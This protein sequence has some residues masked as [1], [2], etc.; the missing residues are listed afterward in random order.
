[1]Q[2]GPLDKSR[3]SLSGKIVVTTRAP[4]Q[5]QELSDA[6]EA[7]GAEVKLLPMVSF[8]PPAN[9]E[10]LDL[11]LQRL[12]EFDWL[13]FTSQNA[14]RFLFRRGCELKNRR[15][16]QPARPLV[17][18]VGAATAQAA[19]NLDI[20]VD[21]VADTHTAPA[22]GAEL[23]H[24]MAGKKVLLP[25]SDRSDDRLPAALREAGATVVEVEAYCT[26]PPDSIDATILESI[27]NGRV[28]VILFASPSA[29]ENFRVAIAP[30]EA[31]ALPDRIKFAA[32]GPTTAE[33]IRAA[34]VDVAIEA[35]E[36]SAA[37]LANAVAEYFEKS[38]SPAR[39]S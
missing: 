19:R 26:A 16:I 22:L 25:R 35:S 27:K 39:Q 9:S 32:I 6:L 33:A 18:A 29:F 28:D 4:E 13:L 15:P 10:E 24:A 1:L 31:A 3:R 20:R 36:A 21:Y 38:P 14:V 37:S 23:R 11:A 34:G 30:D 2:E 8:Q 12:P 5:S 7:L 17:G